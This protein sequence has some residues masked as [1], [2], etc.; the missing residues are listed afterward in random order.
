[1][2]LADIDTNYTQLRINENNPVISPLT[3]YYLALMYC[4]GQRGVIRDRRKALERLNS[5]KNGVNALKVIQLTE[6]K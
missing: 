5:A 2:L 1:M 3:Q 6:L 4:Q